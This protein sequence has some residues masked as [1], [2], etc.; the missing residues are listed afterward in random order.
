MGSKYSSPYDYPE[1]TEIHD[2]FKDSDEVYKNNNPFIK[3]YLNYEKNGTLG[4]ISETL[5]IT[6]NIKFTYDSL[7]YSAVSKR[8]KMI[9]DGDPEYLN[10]ICKRYGFDSLEYNLIAFT[11]D[12]TTGWSKWHFPVSKGKASLSIKIIETFKNDK[13][14]LKRLNCK[15]CNDFDTLVKSIQ[16]KENLDIDFIS[17]CVK[18]NIYILNHRDETVLQNCNKNCRAFLNS[19]IEYKNEFKLNEEKCKEIEIKINETIKNNVKTM[20][21]I[22]IDRELEYI[23]KEDGYYDNDDLYYNKNDDD[24]DERRRQEQQEEEEEL[25]RQQEQEDYDFYFN[26]DDD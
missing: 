3:K 13:Y 23:R 11:R 25:Q 26:N 2:T 20:E 22:E 21:S 5:D 18:T 19:W 4:L 1:C 17:I 24:D 7:V 12:V 8:F 10:V 9:E 15:Y 16:N 6:K 14:H